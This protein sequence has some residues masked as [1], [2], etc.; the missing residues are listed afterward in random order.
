[1]AQVANRGN[2]LPD[3]APLQDPEFIQKFSHNNRQKAGKLVRQIRHKHA[4]GLSIYAQQQKKVNQLQQ[5]LTEMGFPA[6]ELMSPDF[7]DPAMLDEYA[8]MSAYQ[9]TE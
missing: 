6:V 9:S 1:M 7:S 3:Y 2:P 5:E 8:K 4:Y